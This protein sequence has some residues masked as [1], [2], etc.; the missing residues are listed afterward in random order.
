MYLAD[1]VDFVPGHLIFIIFP[2]RPSLFCFQDPPLFFLILILVSCSVLLSTLLSSSTLSFRLFSLQLILAL[3]IAHITAVCVDC[4]ATDVPP[5]AD[6]FAPAK[7]AL[8]F[9]VTIYKI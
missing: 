3:F 4:T 6:P 1:S 9:L 2:H 5:N 7:P 8:T